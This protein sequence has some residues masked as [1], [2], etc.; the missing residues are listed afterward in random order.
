MFRLSQLP[1]F[2]VQQQQERIAFLKGDSRHPMRTLLQSRYRLNET[3]GK[4]KSQCIRML[5]TSS[6]KSCINKADPSGLNQR[7]SDNY[8]YI[9]QI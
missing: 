4:D 6:L 1:V 8:I 9:P 2:A 5:D 7:A 3:I